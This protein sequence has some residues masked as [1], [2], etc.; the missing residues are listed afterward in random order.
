M[1]QEKKSVEILEEPKRKFGGAQPGAGRPKGMTNKLSAVT[2]LN[3]IEAKANGI[4]YETLLANDFLAARFTDDQ[5]LI[6]KWHQ[7]ILSK[8]IADKV[9][10]TTNG[11]TLHAPT[12]NFAPKEIP[13]YID[14]KAIDVKSA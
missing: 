1:E 9:D 3:E 8:V 5:T 12:L 13:D 7:L 11:E 2:L 14:V 10:I 6:H 4:P